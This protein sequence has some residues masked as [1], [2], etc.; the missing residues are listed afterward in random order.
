MIATTSCGSSDDD[1]TKSISIPQV[2][3]VGNQSYT[4]NTTQEV[5][6]SFPEPTALQVVEPPYLEGFTYEII[7]YEFTPDTGNNTSRL[8]FEIKLNNNSDRDVTGLPITTI[9]TG[10]ITGTGPIF[11]NVATTTCPS[12]PANSSCLFTADFE[13]SLNFGNT[14]PGEIIDIQYLLTE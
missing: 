2:Y 3:F 1:C 7:F 13:E 10:D 11:L 14:S 8:R 5:P 4:T 12:I 9:R 6:C